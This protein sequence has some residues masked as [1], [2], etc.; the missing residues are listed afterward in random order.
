MKIEDELKEVMAR[1]LN[2]NDPLQKEVNKLALSMK[3]A[4]DFNIQELENFS[5]QQMKI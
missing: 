5:K 4:D 3:E 1:I 2:A